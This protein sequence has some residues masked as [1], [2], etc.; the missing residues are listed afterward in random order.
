MDETNL[1]LGNLII[2]TG[3]GRGISQSITLFDN[4]DLRRTV[5]G[6]LVD[7]TRDESRKFVSE[8][9]AIDQK[10]PT[11]AG[12]WKGMEISVECISTIRQLVNPPS[13]TVELIRDAVELS[14]FG[15]DVD[16]AKVTPTLVDGRDITFAVNVYL[17]EFFPVLD[18]V[19]SDISIDTDEY[20]STQSWRL[21]LEEL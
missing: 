7:L 19:V 17:V 16:G 14:I 5:N 15:R 13:T 20:E 11:F 2:P 1:K 6:S 18:M 4:G 8:I 3:A 21:S 12:I 9:S 10:T